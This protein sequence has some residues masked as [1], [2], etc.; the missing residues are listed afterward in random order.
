MGELSDSLKVV[1]DWLEFLLKKKKKKRSFVTSKTYERH[2]THRFQIREPVWPRGRAVGPR[3]DTASA[4]RSLQ[5]VV[6]CGHGLVTWS[7]TINET[8]KWLSSL[9]I[10]MQKSFWW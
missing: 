6:V 10:L 9:P 8:F 7:L 3:F 1:S 5:K 2:I 4:L